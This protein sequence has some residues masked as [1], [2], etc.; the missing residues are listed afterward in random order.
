MQLVLGVFGFE[1]QGDR[2]A[3]RSTVDRFDGVGTVSA[4]DPAGGVAFAGLS[5]EQLDGVGHH[6][7]RVEADAELTDQ[8]LGGGSVLGRTQLLT[9]LGGTR[10]GE[11]ADQIHDLVA[12]HT[13]TVV[14]NNQRAGILVH[15][16]LDV[17]IGS[18]DVQVLIPQ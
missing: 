1:V 15:V 16:D 2:R 18:I 17:E 7:R 12:R 13:D 10:L 14:A 5:R 4:G 11:S 6:E 9:Q 3:L 8:F